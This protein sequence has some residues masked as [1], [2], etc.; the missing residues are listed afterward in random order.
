MR[1]HCSKPAASIRRAV[2]AFVVAF[3]LAVPVYAAEADLEGFRTEIDAF[4]GRLGPSSNGAV[5]WAGSD[6]YEIRRDG[7]ALVAVIR[8]VRLA[9]G[10]NQVDSLALDRIEIRRAGQKEDGKLIEFA[11]RLPNRMTL[12]SADGAETK[13]VLKDATASALI[14]AQSGRGRESAIAIA[15]ARLDQTESG[16]WVGIGPLSMASKLVAEPNGGWSGPVEFEVRNVECFVP[17]APIGCGIERIAFSGK[18]AGPSLDSLEKLRETIDGLQ[19]EGN[20]SPEARGA[21]LLSALTSIAA[22]FGSLSGDF[23]VDG[24]TMRSL[25]GE[26]LVSLGKAGTAFTVTGLDSETAAFR[27]GIRHDGLD[28]A[29]SLLDPEKVPNRALVDVGITDISTQAVGKLLRAAAALANEKGEG[30]D[31]KQP[32]NQEATEQMLG[33]LAML[34]PVFHVYDIAVETR[35]VGIDLTGEAKGS[36]LNPN[37]YTAAGD[38]A[39]RGFD[40]L[41]QWGAKL[42]FADYLPVLKELGS[43][44]AAP[45]G[46]PRVTFHLVSAPPKWLTINSSDV[47]AWFDGSEPKPG[48]PRELKPSDPPMQGNDVKNVQQALAAANIAVTEDGVY[49]AATAVAVARFQKQNG[50]NVSGVVDSATRQRL[51]IAGNAPRQGGRN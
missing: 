49:T 7:D 33:A 13:I 42:P 45:D 43:E 48:Q 30:E 4:I 40:D 12:K 29:P 36:P 37:G 28:L 19:A 10:I 14:E 44:R 1:H 41:S 50:I 27:L 8:N 24:L 35:D 2:N 15:S 23:A 18:N 3:A 25:T 31:K 39:I 38:L 16:A 21:A 46:T 32:K 47:S 11:L 6:P 17:Q 9:V 26:P 5:R 20:R 34:N 22:P 51:G